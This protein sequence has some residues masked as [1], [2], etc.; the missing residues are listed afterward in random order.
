[1]LR[2]LSNASASASDKL[3]EQYNQLVEMCQPETA[4]ALIK[5]QL[6]SKKIAMPQTPP[7]DVDKQI[8]QALGW[9]KGKN[10]LLFNAKLEVKTSTPTANGLFSKFCYHDGIF[11][12]FMFG[13]CQTE[14][15]CMLNWIIIFAFRMVIH[16]PVKYK[17]ENIVELIQNLHKTLFADIFRGSGDFIGRF[18]SEDKNTTF[19]VD[20]VNKIMSMQIFDDVTLGSLVLGIKEEIQ[21]MSKTVSI[22]RRV[23]TI[24]KRINV[25]G[26]E[27]RTGRGTVG[28]TRKRSQNPVGVGGGMTRKHKIYTISLNKTRRT[29]T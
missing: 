3:I 12:H 5:S 28:M 13:Q 21:K 26:K 11:S 17:Y 29:N 16:D 24:K 7:G 23:H 27:A 25:G 10:T 15:S 9:N 6:A 4:V 19:Y 8:L 2:G 20:R 22:D 14:Y 18:V 1:M